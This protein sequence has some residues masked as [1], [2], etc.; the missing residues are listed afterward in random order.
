MFV[1]S[2]IKLRAY[3]RDGSMDAKF[4]ACHLRA[5]RAH[6]RQCRTSELIDNGEPTT[7]LRGQSSIVHRGGTFKLSNLPR[8]ARLHREIET[9]RTRCT[10]RCVG[11]TYTATSRELS[12]KFKQSLKREIVYPTLDLM[13][14]YRRGQQRDFAVRVYAKFILARN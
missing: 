14:L 2:A 12:F 1:K 11:P 13:S 10:I 3:A 4:I 7:H 6:A 5:I 9:E 8:R